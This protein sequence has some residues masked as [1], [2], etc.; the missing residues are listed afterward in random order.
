M[1]MELLTEVLLGTKL[2]FLFLATPVAVVA[3]YRH[4][5]SIWQENSR[6]Q[7]RVQIVLANEKDRTPILECAS[8]L[9]REIDE[10]NDD[11]Q[12][13]DKSVELHKTRGPNR[14][15][16]VP[17]DL[18]DHPTIFTVGAERKCNPTELEL[19]DRTHKTYG[20]YV[21]PKAKELRLLLFINCII[22]IPETYETI[23]TEKYPDPESRP[24]F[25]VI[26]WK[27]ASGRDKRRRL[28]GFGNTRQNLDYKCDG[29]DEEGSSLDQGALEDMIKLKIAECTKEVGR[30]F[31]DCFPRYGVRGT[32]TSPTQ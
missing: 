25:D 3:E 29:A 6:R 32:G 11:L 31:E 23:I 12:V 7:V 20:E 15:M 10:R 19:F 1:A 22:T 18:E 4:V 28:Y 14:G 30:K 26:A 2:S 8:S 21:C 13:N 24:N 9:I 17:E 27:D 16:D 5:G